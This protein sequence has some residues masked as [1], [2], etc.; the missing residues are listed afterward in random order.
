MSNTV[1]IHSFEVPGAIFI[2]RIAMHEKIYAQVKKFNKKLLNGVKLHTIYHF[3]HFCI[4]SIIVEQLE[5][6]FAN[7]HN[8]GCHSVYL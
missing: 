8:V 1:D 6:H 2:K 5:A 7:V 3:K 4:N